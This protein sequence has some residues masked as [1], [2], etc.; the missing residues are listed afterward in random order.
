MIIIAGGC[1]GYF[2][3]DDTNCEWV[4]V[5]E[6]PPPPKGKGKGMDNRGKGGKGPKRSKAQALAPACT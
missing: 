5:P 1:T 3:C 6:L 2:G 4:G